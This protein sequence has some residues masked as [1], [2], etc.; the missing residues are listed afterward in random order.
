MSQSL[1]CRTVSQ[2]PA[3]RNAPSVSTL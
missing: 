3:A 1:I 2:A